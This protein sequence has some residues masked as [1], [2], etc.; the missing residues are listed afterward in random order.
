MEEMYI[1]HEL[2]GL[3]PEE[4]EITEHTAP[5]VPP[6][7]TQ[8]PLLETEQEPEIE[9]QEIQPEPIIEP[10]T[11]HTPELNLPPEPILEHNLP[12]IPIEEPGPN[13]EMELAQAYVRSQPLDGVFPPEEGL[14]KGTAF[15]N[16]FK[17]YSGRDE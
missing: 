15:P 6:E 17:P 8:L 10:A 14:V 5:S 4:E 12:F 3:P 2:H 1:L 16:L 13:W 9:P 7:L 11:V